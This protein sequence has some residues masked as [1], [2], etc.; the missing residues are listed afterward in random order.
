MTGVPLALSE[1]VASSESDRFRTGSL[2]GPGYHFAPYAGMAA[3]AANE[4]RGCGSNA[5]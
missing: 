1:M 2:L 3:A 5:L 4:S